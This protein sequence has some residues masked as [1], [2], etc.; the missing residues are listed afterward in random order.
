MGGYVRQNHNTKPKKSLERTF[1]QNK[2]PKPGSIVAAIPHLA[3][4]H[5]RSNFE[6]QLYLY[7]WKQIKSNWNYN[8]IPFALKWIVTQ[9]W[10]DM[11]FAHAFPALQKAFCLCLMFNG[12][13]PHT[14]ILLPIDPREEWIKS[15]FYQSGPFLFLAFLCV[16]MTIFGDVLDCM[17]VILTPHVTLRWNM[18]IYGF[19]IKQK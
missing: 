6:P 8:K 1:I 17:G 15:Y 10:C 5:Y 3:I 19:W 2:G 9:P 14:E 13:L 4:Q 12:I 7:K 16:L 18:M 11:G